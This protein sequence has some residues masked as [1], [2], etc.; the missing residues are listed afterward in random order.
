MDALLD[1]DST[2][3]KVELRCSL[4]LTCHSCAGIVE[5][6]WE[7]SHTQP[8]AA[9]PSGPAHEG[10]MEVRHELVSTGTAKQGLRA[11]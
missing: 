4:S 3:R 5:S 7:G 10:T 2:W 11:I 1:L 9:R 6:S 8:A